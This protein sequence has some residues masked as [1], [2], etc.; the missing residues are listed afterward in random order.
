MKGNRLLRA[1]LLAAA[2]AVVLTGCKDDESDGAPSVPEIRF[3][4]SGVDVGAEGGVQTL[5]YEIAGDK[6]PGTLEARVDETVGWVHSFDTSEAGVLRFEVDANDTEAERT[7]VVYVTW[8]GAEQVQLAVRQA[9]G[10][11]GMSWV[12][13]VQIENWEV[14]LNV[15]PSDDAQA[16]FA[17]IQYYDVYEQMG[18]TP[19]EFAESVVADMIA[20]YGEAAGMTPEE[21][22]AGMSIYG[23]ASKPYGV[24]MPGTK[25]IAFAFALSEAGEVVSD[26]KIENFETPPADP[27]DNRIS[28]R[29]D[30]V[31]ARTADVYYTTTNSDVYLY[32]LYD[33]VPAAEIEGMTDEQA[34]TH[35]ISNWGGYINYAL[36]SGDHLYEAEYLEPGTDY[37]AVGF[38]YDV[39][40]YTTA[41]TKVAFHTDEPGDPAACEFGFRFESS[42][43]GT[44]LVSVDPSDETVRYFWNL[45]DASASVDDIKALIEESIRTNTENGYYADVF[46][47]WQ[48]ESSIGKDSYLFVGLDPDKTYRAAAVALD[49]KTGGFGGEFYLS[50]V[51]PEESAGELSIELV[52]DKYFDGDQAAELGGEYASF[53]GKAL[54]PVSVRVNGAGSYRWA[55]TTYPEDYTS[56]SDK[57]FWSTLSWEEIFYEDEPAANIALDWD[58][59]YTL[60]A[61]VR[62]DA[63]DAYKRFVQEVRF[64]KQGAS[65]IGELTPSAQP[66]PLC[67]APLTGFRPLAAEGR[68]V[69]RSEAAR[70][71]EWKALARQTERQYPFGALPFGRIDARR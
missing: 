19:K 36:T 25:Y 35:I 33:V 21:V 69:D 45:Y 52:Y 8:P 41:L 1:W 42:G 5:A 48:N 70:R 11:G 62:N 51:Y 4:V 34:M 50:D 27:S 24:I 13:D 56:A 38:G 37:V 67:A 15:T 22:I 32:Y 10:E 3:E 68:A 49:L 18:L 23:P 61:M 16:Y 54:V 47:Y 12:F 65:P 30:N 28:I 55:V 17:D 63:G 59:D 9:P 43:P 66:A 53:A 7:A 64:T 57:S 20:F 2:C 6:E 46:E 31:T 39:L 58:V 29:V 60:V 14:T 40:T 44:V 26:V 71:A